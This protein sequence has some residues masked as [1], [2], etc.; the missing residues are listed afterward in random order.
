[1]NLTVTLGGDIP[2]AAWVDFRENGS[3]WERML[4]DRDVGR[5]EYS[6]AWKELRNSV[7][8][9][10]EA[11]D[12]RSATHR[13]DVLPR[14][15]IESRSAEIQPPK[16]T[17][18]APT[19]VKDFTIL[20]GIVPGSR[21]VFNLEFTAPVG[22]VRATDGKGGKLSVNRVDDTHWRIAGTMTGSQAVTVDYRDAT[23]RADADSLQVTVKP[24]EPPKINITAPREG[25]EIV[26]TQDG[27]LPLQFT[28][29]ANFGLSSLA[30]YKSTNDK[31]DA[32]LVQEWKDAATQKIIRRR[33][34]DSAPSIRGSR[35]RPRH[36]LCDRQRSERCHRSW[37]H[38]FAPHCRFTQ[39]R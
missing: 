26:M 21:V 19:V 22:E 10:I 14:T 4:L 5:P 11:G 25:R 32:Q 12:A 1:M 13:I 9:Y 29:T 34:R 15:V 24:D 16:Y 20:G 3:T 30:V 2:K 36:I 28:A 23:G 7:E 38:D 39:I 33:D 8:Y 27:V 35:R 37:R 18:L 31:P 6:F 17:K